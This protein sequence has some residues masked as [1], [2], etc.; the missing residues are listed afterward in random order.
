M[1]RSAQRAGCKPSTHR[2]RFVDN[3]RIL[4]NQYRQ[5]LSDAFGVDLMLKAAPLYDIG[6]LAVPAA[7]LPPVP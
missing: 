1:R 5:D 6:K 4:G 7:V 2:D 3:D